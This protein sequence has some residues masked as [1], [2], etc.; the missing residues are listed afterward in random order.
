MDIRK[1]KGGVGG[2]EDKVSYTIPSTGALGEENKG[3]F[4]WVED[5]IDLGM[6]L[7]GLNP[8]VPSNYTT[9]GLLDPL[10]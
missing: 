10:D 3:R 7:L 6:Q 4:S 8:S 9:Y 1:C 2:V 5:L